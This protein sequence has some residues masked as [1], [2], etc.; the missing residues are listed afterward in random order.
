M[1]KHYFHPRTRAETTAWM[2]RELDVPHEVVDV[3]IHAGA[4]NEPAFR[5]LNPMGKLPVLVDGDAVVTETPAICAYLADRF[6]EKGLAPPFDSPLR[7]PY[8][9]YLF[10]PHVT[11][12]PLL[13][14]RSLGIED[15]NAFSMGFGDLPR[16][17]DTIEAMTP[18]S[19]WAL[20]DFTAADVVFGGALAFFTGFGM[21]QASPKVAAYV[22]RIEARPAYAGDDSAS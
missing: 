16:V 11:V 8:Y 21:L 7:G 3:D 14:V 5:A 12:E 17:S 18:E 10:F 22:K 9:R 4:Q 2:L 19:G 20:G 13:S 1:L 6:P 15:V